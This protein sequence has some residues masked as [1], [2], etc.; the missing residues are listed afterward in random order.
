MVKGLL[1]SL[2]EPSLRTAALPPSTRF[3]TI[4]SV[5]YST[6][7]DA[8]GLLQYCPTVLLLGGWD[9]Y[10]RGARARIARALVSE[11]VGFGVR[12]GKKTSSRLDPLEIRADVGETI[13]AS[14]DHREWGF[15][16]EKGWNKK[17]PAEIGHSNIPPSIEN[18]GVTFKQAVQTTVLSLVQI[19]NLSFGGP[20]RDLAGRSLIAA[21]GL[22]A[23]ESLRA[24]GYF[25]RSRCQLLPTV[26]SI[27]IVGTSADEVEPFD[28][29]LDNAREG[30]SAA[31]EAARS[32]GLEW[33]GR[34]QLDPSDRL[35]KLVELSD[36]AGHGGE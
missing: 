34:I 21:L 35:K 11:V 8:V 22:Y 23:A 15:K 31:I 30:L 18:G 25:F 12:E 17:T 20:E 5:L 19:R 29:N 4:S 2:R 33:S 28:L 13:Y 27:E 14:P 1:D 6:E 3:G 24:E 7:R 32:S 26:R 10:G 9:S 36:A 16:Q